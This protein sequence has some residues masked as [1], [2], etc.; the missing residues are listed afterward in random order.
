MKKG[1]LSLGLIALLSSSSLSAQENNWDISISSRYRNL[2]LG[3]DVE[4][5][6][7][8][9]NQPL[10]EFFSDFE[11]VS[12]T[13]HFFDISM[14]ARNIYQ[15]N[16][17]VGLGPIFSFSVFG[18][19]SR[20]YDENY[21]VYIPRSDIQIGDMDIGFNS[22]LDWYLNASVGMAAYLQLSDWLRL[23]WAIELGVAHMDSQSTFSQRLNAEEPILEAAREMGKAAR[24]ISETDSQGTGF[25]FNLNGGPEFLFSNFG[26]FINGGFILER[27]NL[28]NTTYDYIEWELEEIR[29]TYPTLDASGPFGELGLRYY[30]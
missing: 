12:P 11:N 9:I 10:N 13:H 27:I 19:G 6:Y 25:S 24:R 7:N 3:S 15:I 26:I 30:F 28:H 17:M 22:H 5:F 8:Q 18:G 16:E 4:Q 23:N 2:R 21:S 29:H 20:E 1:I 14:K